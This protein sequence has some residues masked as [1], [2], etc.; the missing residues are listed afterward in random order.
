MHRLRV[1]TVL[2]LVMMPPSG[3]PHQFVSAQRTIAGLRHGARRTRRHGRSAGVGDVQVAWRMRGWRSNWGRLE[4]QDGGG[5][6]GEMAEVMR[7]HAVIFGLSLP[8][9]RAGVPV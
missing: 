4:K 5:G 2:A 1:P 7:S 6:E 9:S 3:A 8:A